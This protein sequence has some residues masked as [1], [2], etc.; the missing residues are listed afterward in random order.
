VLTAHRRRQSIAHLIPQPRR[1]PLHRVLWDAIRNGRL[2][3][4]SNKEWLDIVKWVQ[5]QIDP[6]KVSTREV[7]YI[8]AANNPEKRKW[9]DRP[10]VF[11]WGEDDDD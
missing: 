9:G 2:R 11:A 3:K 5:Q 7:K 8:G 4:L 6:P 10:I 1:H